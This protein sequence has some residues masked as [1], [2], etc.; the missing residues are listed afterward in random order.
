MNP[1]GHL[2]L[3]SR[4]RLLAALLAAPV[5]LTAMGVSAV[6]I[7][8]SRDPGAP[9][10]TAAATSSYAD[11][12]ERNADLSHVYEFIRAGQDP[13]AL[14]RVRHPTL[15]DGRS[16]LVSPLLWA[17]AMRRG[18]VVLML[19]SFG[20]RMDR[21]SDRMSACLAD[22]L[23]NPEL[24]DL[25]RR[26]GQASPADQCPPRAAVGAPL[27]SFIDSPVSVSPEP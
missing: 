17:V 5:V 9:L 6:E 8:R 22:A 26:Y 18:D 21:A 13:N 7:W 27:L 14:I 25:L 15:T 24:A 1:T 23:G 19:L 11:A 12:V 4:S 16:V 3:A 20:A 2:L 10:F